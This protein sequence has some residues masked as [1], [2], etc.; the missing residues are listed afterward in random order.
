MS[1]TDN[2]FLM[3]GNSIKAL[4]LIN[5]I[6]EKF[7]TQLSISDIFKY[8][9]VPQIAR[10]IREKLLEREYDSENGDI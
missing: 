10:L 9:T 5:K 7:H 4:Q 8:N 6:N 1:S 2:F 3:G